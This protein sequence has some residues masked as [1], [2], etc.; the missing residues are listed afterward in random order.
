[1]DF[2]EGLSKSEDMD[3][4]LVVVDRFTKYAHFL[5]LKHP[6]TASSVAAMFAKEVVHLHDFPS[7]IV[8]D[9]DRIFLSAF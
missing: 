8:S 3:T 1:M 4:V 5:R 7:S 9:R 2:V 6:F